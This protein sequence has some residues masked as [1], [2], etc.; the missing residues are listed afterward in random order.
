MSADCCSTTTGS[1]DSASCCPRCGTKGKSIDAITP[2]ALLT[3]AA[4]RRG[5]PA[6][7]LFCAESDCEVVYFGEGQVFSRSDVKVDVFAKA[8]TAD[9][10]PVCYCF[11]HSRASIRAAIS[12]E[13]RSSASSDIA[14]LVRAGACAC[15]VRNPKGSCC[16]ADVRQLEKELTA[17]LIEV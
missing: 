14:E 1:P 6:R 15:E 13:G 11:A 12:I 2:K 10:T 7:P 16:L 8:P 3:S 17:T 4:L 5:V 9:S